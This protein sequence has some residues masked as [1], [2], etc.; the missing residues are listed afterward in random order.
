MLAGL[1]ADVASGKLQPLPRRLYP[2][3][4]A[5]DAFRFMG[6]G[7][8]TGKIVL[9]QT[10]VTDLRSDASYL[11]TGGL[12]GLGLTCARLLAEE[13]A[14]HLILI[15]RRLPSADTSKVLDELRSADVNIQIEQADV[16]D[17]DQMRAVV[18]R[19]RNSMPPLRGILHAAGITDDGMLTAQTLE[20]FREVMKSKVQGGWHLHALTAD[21]PLDFFVTFSSSAALTGSAGQGNYVAANAFLDALCGF[22]QARG[23]PAMSIQW[24]IWS[25]VGMGMAVDESHHRRWASMGVSP[26]SPDVGT[27]MLSQLM[28]GYGGAEVAAIPITRSRLPANLGP[29]FNEIRTEAAKPAGASG[30][31]ILRRLENLPKAEKGKELLRFLSEQIVNVLAL[32]SSFKIDPDRSL[33][34]L[35]LDSLMAMELR[36]RLQS[37]LGVTVPVDELLQGKSLT[38]LA[39]RVLSALP[40]ESARSSAQESSSNVEREEISL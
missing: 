22:R 37:S 7:L 39:E 24:G 25:G 12:G 6:Q 40:A 16:A 30:A 23:L 18:E 9:T 32:G 13:G 2:I 34:D 35:G 26:I 5:E 11:V 38:Q 20:R 21:M 14:K 1:L 31:D 28:H 8:H 19:T 33:M 10:R 27:R 3:E 36:N 29:F 17:F 4:K 15:S